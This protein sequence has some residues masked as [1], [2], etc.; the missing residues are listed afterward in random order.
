MILLI[1]LLIN[2]SIQSF[3]NQLYKS[4][5]STIKLKIKGKGVRAFLSSSFSSSY[6]PNEI[7]INN[8]QV[9]ISSYQYDFPYEENIVEL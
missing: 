4:D 6:Y 3:I 7:H 1:L 5:F 8:N 9:T 2:I